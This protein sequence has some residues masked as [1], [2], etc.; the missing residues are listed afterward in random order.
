MI[1]IEKKKTIRVLQITEELSAAGIESFIMNNYRRID[2]SKVQF[3]F[4]VLRNGHEFYDDEIEKLGGK[5]YWVHSNITNTLL[6]V[7]V[8]S[9][10]IYTFLKKHHYNIV[11]IHYTTPLRATYLLA[12]KMAGV[13]VRIYHSHSAWVS[14]KSRIKKIVYRIMRAGITRWATHYFACS[15]AAAKWM[16]SKKVLQNNNYKVIYNGINIKKFAYN[17]NMRNEVRNEFKIESKFVIIHTGRFLE[18]KNHAFIIDVFKQLKK[19]CPEAYLIML[20]TGKLQGKI[21]QKVHDFNLDK[22]VIFLDVRPDVNRFLNAA[23]CYIMPSLY[24]G[25]PVAAVEAECAGLPCVLSDNITKEVALTGKV[26]FLS[27]LDSYDTW[28]KALLEYRYEKRSDCASEIIKNGYDV[29]KVAHD[30]QEFYLTTLNDSLLTNKDYSINKMIDTKEKYC[31]VISVEENLYR[32]IGY[33][34]RFHAFV[35]QCEVGKLF[36]YIQCLR[37]DELYSNILK[38][39]IIFKIKALYWRRQHNKLGIM[40]GI[41]IPINTFGKG[42]LVYHS[43]SIIVHRDSHCGEY[44]KLHGCNCIGNSGRESKGNNT[45]HVGNYLDLG[46]GA[47]IIGNVELANNITVAANAVVCKSCLEEGSVLVGMPAIPIRNQAEIGR[48]RI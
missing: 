8:E 27:L 14:G 13:Q 39:S 7:L 1:N 6:R 2:R 42:L 30:L 26:K 5:K 3:D 21:K 34:G 10:Q 28:C 45:P 16:F 18:Q 25:L 33:K 22:D 31:E 44:C 37:K 29:E 20:G 32:K 24:E 11:H 4:L 12:A 17:A 47:R 35:T 9:K 19:E 46:V 43:Q 15:K 48:K 40:L 36:R 23:D 38:K 41:S